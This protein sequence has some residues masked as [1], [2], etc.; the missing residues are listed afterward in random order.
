MH[1]IRRR[2]LLYGASVASVGALLAGCGIP[3]APLSSLNATPPPAHESG[4]RLRV[5]VLG[6][7]LS[8]DPHQLTP[9]VPDTLFPI[10]DR[11]M[12]YGPHTSPQASLAEN[13]QMSNG[14][15]DLALTL[16]KGVHFHSGRELTT[17]DVHWTLMR[18][19]PPPVRRVAAGRPHPSHQEPGLLAARSA[20]RGRA[21]L[22][23]L[24]GPA[25]DGHRAGG[26][27]ARPGSET[28][29]ARH[30]ATPTT[31]QRSS[32]TPWRV[33]A[34]SAVRLRNLSTSGA[35]PQD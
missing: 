14:G 31:R 3:L 20:R 15:R 21:V 2:R 22:S 32:S 1:P 13:W 9:P 33:V 19:R 8:L 6:D 7:I 35:L 17:S 16:R 28:V 10:W 5:G 18:H 24:Q 23:G 25:G 12:T 27:H 30:G 34:R 26:R 29:A 4:S 11:L